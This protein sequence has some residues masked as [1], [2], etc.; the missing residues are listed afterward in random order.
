MNLV[1]KFDQYKDLVM[2]VKEHNPELELDKRYIGKLEGHYAI[3]PVLSYDKSTVPNLPDGEQKIFDLI[4]K[5]LVAA[6]LPPA[7][8]EK[9]DIEGKIEEYLFLSKFKNYTDPGYL[10]YIKGKK[11]EEVISVG[12][13]K[14]DVV[15]GNIEEKKE[16]T[17]APK[18][19]KDTPLLSLMEKAHLL[20]QDKKLKKALKEAN[21]IGTAAT[22]ASFAPLL[23]K[24]GYI[25]KEKGEYIPTELGLSLYEILPEKLTIPD[26][27]A[28]LE[29]DLSRFIKNE[30][31][32]TL[33]EIL[34]ETSTFLNDV[35][36]SM[37]D[38]P[39]VLRNSAP[40]GRCPKCHSDVVEEE[41][42]FR[43]VSCDL[44]VWKNTS[45]AEINTEDMKDILEK[46]TT[47]K[48]FD[49]KS[50]SGS[51]FKAKLSFSK[52]SGRIE[53][54]FQKMEYEGNHP[55]SPKQVGIIEKHGDEETLAALKEERFDQCREW[56]DSYFKGK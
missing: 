37:N 11:E 10:S 51:P 26:F 54:L 2:A 1:F 13:K 40:I 4:V 17:T 9:T 46:G 35:F 48:V 5:R 16:K 50:R 31:A 53:F 28:A 45:D 42:L 32:K 55:L 8:G 52:R 36:S 3:I 15:S 21:G 39:N 6:L 22:R 44:K 33:R 7:K 56:L 20:I 27:S 18:I 49:M 43:C 14:G 19:Y 41:R 30:N 25:K 24:R 12:Y 29:F 38:C 23:V 47:R 34:N